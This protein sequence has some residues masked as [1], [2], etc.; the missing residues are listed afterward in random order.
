MEIYRQR[1]VKK[2][3]CLTNA[4]VCHAVPVKALNLSIH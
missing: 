2:M 1:T 4:S 3:M